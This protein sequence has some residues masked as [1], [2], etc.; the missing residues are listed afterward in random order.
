MIRV[1]L[2]G[3]AL[4]LIAM[5]IAYFVCLKA[6]KEGSKVFQYGGY[7]IGVIILVISLIL[8]IGDIARMRPRRIPPR[9]SGI[10][11]TIPRTQRE[12]PKLPPELEKTLKQRQVK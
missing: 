7:A 3:W 4:V 6:S 8:A 1:D 2:T 11:P 9:R 12:M 5:A 10:S